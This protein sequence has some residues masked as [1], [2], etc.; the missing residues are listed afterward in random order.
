[1]I[2]LKSPLFEVIGI[3]TVA[4]NTDVDQVTANTF[5]VLDVAE[6][7]IEIPVAKGCS[8]PLIETPHFCPTIHGLDGLGNLNDNA[9]SL[10][11]LRPEHAVNFLVTTLLNSLEPITLIPIAPLTN[12]AMALRLEPRIK[13]KIERI[14]LMGGSAEL[15]GNCT[16]WA[17]ANIF[18]DPEAAHIVFNSGVKNIV[19]YGLDV[20]SKLSFTPQEVREFLDSPNPWAQFSGK[21]MT[22][23][24]NT[25][26]LPTA[27]IGD[28]GAV[29][30][31]ALPQ[32]IKTELLHVSIE[33]QGTH[34][35]G[36]T[37][38]DKRLYI[39]GEDNARLEPNVHVVKDI[40]VDEFK[41]FFKETLFS[42]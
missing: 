41:A 26:K 38:A 28:A 33:L 39:F 11:K 30:S 22:F 4:G 31:V 24:L 37:V 32:F 6:A 16:A 3:T 14:V 5:K 23:D 1:M 19:M 17:E 18:C 20:Y 7:P 42:K 21:L 29:I 12:I 36:M 10:R 40:N 9:P 34:T 35:R 8:A 25:F 13:D 27:G 15:G 2:A